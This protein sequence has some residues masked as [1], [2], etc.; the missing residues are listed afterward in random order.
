MFGIV[1][2]LFNSELRGNGRNAIKP[3]ARGMDSV[4][5][6]ISRNEN[7]KDN[8]RNKSVQ[9]Q[10]MD[11]ALNQSSVA[12]LKKDTKRYKEI[13][14][15]PF[16]DIGRLSKKRLGK[17]QKTLLWTAAGI[18]RAN[19]RGLLSLVPLWRRGGV[20]RVGGILSFGVMSVLNIGSFIV[21]GIFKISKMVIGGLWKFSTGIVKTVASGISG[22]YKITI[23]PILPYIFKF[24]MTPQGAFIAGYAAHVMYNKISRK[25]SSEKDSMNG[26]LPMLNGFL[27][28]IKDFIK[29]L[30][31]EKITK[32]MKYFGST[33]VFPILKKVLEGLLPKN[34]MLRGIK[35]LGG[36]ALGWAT[37]SGKILGVV[38]S[39][40]S[41][42]L[43]SIPVTWPFMLAG[44]AFVVM[45]N[46]LGEVIRNSK[47]RQKELNLGEHYAKSLQKFQRKT[48]K[49]KYRDFKDKNKSLIQKVTG[50][51]DGKNNGAVDANQILRDIFTQGGNITDKEYT[52]SDEIGKFCETQSKIF[53]SERKSIISDSEKSG[54]D[55]K[56]QMQYQVMINFN[57]VKY[58]SNQLP[59]EITN[60]IEL[61]TKNLLSRIKLLDMLK[62][63]K[64]AKNGDL[65]SWKDEINA[66]E[67][68]TDELIVIKDNKGFI[69]DKVLGGLKFYTMDTN[70]RYDKDGNIM[71][72]TLGGFELGK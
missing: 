3:N 20:A 33:F 24:L 9:R 49:A 44:A 63:R 69:N 59:K 35:T 54:N 55:N 56:R 26:I 27:G 60:P 21:S 16:E 72:N 4:I 15:K 42:V 58:L 25:F 17:I 29:N 14:G 68:A 51:G 64:F 11:T 28:R 7:K 6:K 66:Y 47:E 65:T 48:R 8:V 19:S 61:R 52:A 71:T 22:I 23:K 32:N 13:I 57:D 18:R 38:R 53:E 62:N 36:K 31:I 40:I 10:I 50:M 41:G 45:G 70:R 1:Q 12:K 2:K 39:A 5:E 34:L 30:D 67:K 46:E 43:R 37:H